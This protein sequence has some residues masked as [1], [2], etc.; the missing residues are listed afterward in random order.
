M[1]TS[2]PPSHDANARRDKRCF[3]EMRLPCV[4]ICLKSFNLVCDRSLSTCSTTL[5]SYFFDQGLCPAMKD[6]RTFSHRACF[7]RGFSRF[8]HR[9]FVMNS[10]TGRRLLFFRDPDFDMRFLNFLFKCLKQRIGS[11]YNYRIS[12]KGFSYPRDPCQ[13]SFDHDIEIQ[14]R[15]GQVFPEPS[16]QR[17]IHLHN[18][19][20][21]NAKCMIK[22]VSK[23][24]I[25]F[26]INTLVSSTFRRFNR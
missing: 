20:L 11:L 7:S 24:L 5:K 23:R 25:F 17:G 26:Y 6:F 22:A 19:W 21:F 2:S 3:K 1:P 9:C 14:G 13:M 16:D 10:L 15:T 12:R 4:G 8:L 18:R